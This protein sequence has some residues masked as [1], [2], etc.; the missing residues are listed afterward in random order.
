MLE[1]GKIAIKQNGIV[2]LYDAMGNYYF[3]YF[4]L[5]YLGKLLII[6]SLQYVHKAKY[7]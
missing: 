1:V 5:E 4:S 2:E 3:S 6:K 7:L